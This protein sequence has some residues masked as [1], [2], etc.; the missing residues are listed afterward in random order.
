MPALVQPVEVD[1]LG[2]R[3]LDPAPRRRVG[4][5]GKTLTATGMATP[6]GAKKAILFSQYR[7]AE[8]TPVFVNQ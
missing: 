5:S 1:E 3:A 4:S 2:I 6:F 8:E 7:R